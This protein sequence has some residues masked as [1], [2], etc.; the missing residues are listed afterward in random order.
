[1]LINL[2]SFTKKSIHQL[3]R[4]FHTTR[5]LSL[6]EVILHLQPPSQRSIL[7]SWII[8]QSLLL[9]SSTT[10]HIHLKRMDWLKLSLHVL[11]AFE[12]MVL[13]VASLLS[14]KR[15][16]LSSQLPRNC[17]GSKLLSNTGQFSTT[18]LCRQC[19]SILHRSWHYSISFHVSMHSSW[20]S[21]HHIEASRSGQSS[22]PFAAW[23]LGGSFLLACVAVA[24]AYSNGHALGES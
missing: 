20:S 24:M 23:M 2:E 17:L 6:T 1:M 21:S 13:P 15:V 10:S 18:L 16:S 7:N 5:P 22:C 12:S 3:L 11:S 9:D 14:V 8:Y 19:I 4:D